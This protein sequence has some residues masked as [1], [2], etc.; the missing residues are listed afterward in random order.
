MPTKTTQLRPRTDETGKTGYPTPS[1]SL[2]A[3]HSI[4]G[5]PFSYLN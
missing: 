4:L 2:V 1:I 3:K 5:M